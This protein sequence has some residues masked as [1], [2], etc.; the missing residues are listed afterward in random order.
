M[1][2]DETSLR[3][4]VETIEGLELD[5]ERMR[6]NLEATHG[7]IL[8]EA[9]AMALAVRVGKPQAHEIL[10]RASRRAAESGRELRDVL[11][12]DPAGGKHLTPK[13]LAAVFD[14]RHWLGQSAA[15]VDRV[16]AERRR[17]REAT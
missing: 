4:T 12:E 13:E 11:A 15:F 6:A 8:A 1:L 10:E 3:Q 5:P 7:R 9:A 2:S 17:R 14:P 16:L